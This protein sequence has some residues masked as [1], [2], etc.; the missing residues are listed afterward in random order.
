[1]LTVQQLQPTVT[2]LHELQNNGEYVGYP[3]NSFV[4]GLL[5]QLNFDEKRIRGYSYPDEYVEALKKGSQSGG[6][7][8]IVHEIPYIKAFLSKHCKASFVCKNW[9]EMRDND[10]DKSISQRLISWV[11]YYNNKDCSAYYT[12]RKG[13]GEGSEHDSDRTCRNSGEIPATLDDDPPTFLMFPALQEKALLQSLRVHVRNPDQSLLL[14]L[15]GSVLGLFFFHKQDLALPTT[16]FSYHSATAV[17]ITKNSKL[18]Q[19]VDKE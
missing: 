2:D 9:H 19:N 18:P 8:A 5:M 15:G 16:D 12:F 14:D 17:G 13:N 1:M 6:V 4:K 11:R 3:V 7:A 10:R